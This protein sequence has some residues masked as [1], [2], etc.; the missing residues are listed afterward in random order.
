MSENTPSAFET[1]RSQWKAEQ[2][3]M[4]RRFT[5]GQSSLK[6]C[7]LDS[8]QKAEKEQEAQKIR[9]DSLTEAITEML[10]SN[11]KSAK[12]QEQH[13]KYQAEAMRQAILNQQVD[14]ENH[15]QEVMQMF[16]L[17]QQQLMSLI[18]KE[19]QQ[20]KMVE[21]EKMDNFQP[22]I[23]VDCE[24]VPE[25]S[26]NEGEGNYL[27]DSA[28][29]FEECDLDSDDDSNVQWS[30]PQ[31]ADTKKRKNLA[32]PQTPEREQAKGTNWKPST[33]AQDIN[34]CMVDR[35]KKYE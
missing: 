32:S 1:A 33:H 13:A 30:T 15:K 34:N 9:L 18:K 29:E 6:K 3:E 17:F 11:T 27:K 16:T 10:K 2:K 31:N 20:Q 35:A 26:D 21:K 23:G 25:E 5:A 22:D 7:M 28:Q 12:Q 4:E 24:Q 8:A 19:F 14:Q